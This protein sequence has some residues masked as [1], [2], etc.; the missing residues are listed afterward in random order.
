M[1]PVGRRGFALA[2]SLWAIA[3]AGAVIAAAA[4]H[5]RDAVS[6]ARNR[7]NA[8]RAQWVAAGCVERALA[9]ATDE[10]W[11]EGTTPQSVAH[12][13]NGLDSAL[14]AHALPACG[15]A[16]RPTGLTADVNNL[17]GPALHR[18]LQHVGIPSGHISALTDALLDWI[19][20]DDA[21]RPAGAEAGWYAAWK[22]PRPRNAPLRSIDELRLVRGFEDLDAAQLL[23]GTE[24][25]R[26]LW[27][28]A[29]TSVLSSLPGMTD[30][31]LSV[32]ESRGRGSVDRLSL[33]G[34]FPEMSTDARAALA[35][36]AP[37][38]AE[39]TTSVPEAWI[40]AS[41]VAVGTPPVS[42]TVRMQVT[43]G[44]RRLHELGLMIQR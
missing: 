7:S 33:V 34:D 28:R 11:P 2:A 1:M 36:A 15:M 20:D 26:I 40:I 21:T 8:T 22:R 29:E 25:G 39:L 24:Q 31:A 13:W 18:L 4:M 3:A 14:A 43:L 30:E 42:V 27:P 35:H 5:A 6:A 10:L 16:V 41:T 9:S 19:D 12:T 23:L 17:S 38:L 32:L 44:E 37:D